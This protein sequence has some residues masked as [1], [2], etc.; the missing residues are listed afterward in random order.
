MDPQPLET[1]KVAALVQHP[2]FHPHGLVVAGQQ[3]DLVHRHEQRVAPHHGG[4]V[5]QDGPVKVEGVDQRH[6]HAPLVP[7]LLQELVE[8]LGVQGVVLGPPGPQPLVH[9]A[10]VPQAVAALA[11]HRLFPL[12][13]LLLLEVGLF[14]AHGNGT[15]RTTTTTSFGR[16]AHR[17]FPCRQFRD[18]L[19]VHV[20]GQVPRE[21]GVFE[22]KFHPTPS[23][24]RLFEHHLV[25]VGAGG[26]FAVKP[27]VGALPASRFRLSRGRSR[28]AS[29]HVVAR[30]SVVLVA[31]A[32]RGLPGQIDVEAIGRPSRHGCR[33]GQRRFGRGGLRRLGLGYAFNQ[34]GFFP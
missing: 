14:T 1:C 9:H 27:V 7:H 31:E 13:L 23:A 16:C 6:H 8:E 30:N 21:R 25:V 28:Q 29:V 34:L 33:G 3:V 26:L 24:L 17:P 2:L 11:D 19:V 22:L 20:V 4:E 5:G 18:P 15:Q 12:F 32:I 10:V